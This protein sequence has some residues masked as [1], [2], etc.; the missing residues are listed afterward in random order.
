MRSGNHLQ[1]RIT[2]IIYSSRTGK[3]LLEIL[4]Y[5]MPLI[6]EVMHLKTWYSRS[7][8]E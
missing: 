6:H 5:G 8:E 1:I 4:K 2:G 7:F 3:A